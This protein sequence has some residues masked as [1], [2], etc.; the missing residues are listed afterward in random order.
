[1]IDGQTKN[2]TKPSFKDNRTLLQKIEQLP[3]GPEWICQ[4][5][6]VVGD[7]VDI[8][9]VPQNESVDV[10][11]RDPIDCIKELLGNPMFADHMHYAPEKVFTDETKEEA[12]FN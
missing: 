2:L 5:V 7:L 12:I 11:F 10:W 8:N 1:M 9:G 6:N 4:T 3:T